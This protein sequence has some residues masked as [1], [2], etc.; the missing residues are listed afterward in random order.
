M[1]PPG[2]NVTEPISLAANLIRVIDS[3]KAAPDDAKA[4]TTKIETFQRA[5]RN[6]QRVLERSLELDPHADHLD[7]RQTLADCQVCVQQCQR[8]QESFQKLSS[9][10][11]A[12]MANASQAAR[13]V[14]NHRQIIKLRNEIDAQ[15]TNVG[16]TLLFKSM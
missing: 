3:L 11:I 16:L 14:W 15:M 7:L 9:D 5:L 1:I 2:W 8:F 13:W 4:F 10:G 12:N 6:L